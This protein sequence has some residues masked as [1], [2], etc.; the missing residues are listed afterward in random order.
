VTGVMALFFLAL[1]LLVEALQVP[2][3]TDPSRWMANGGM[4]AALV[5][6]G[7]LVADVLLPVPSSLIMIAHG[8]LF[9]VIA[10]SCLSLVGSTGAALAAFA[11]GR[12]GGPLLGRLVPR[13]ERERADRLLKKYGALAIVITRPVPILAE[14]VA[15]MA[16][17]ATL[18]WRRMLAASAAGSLPAAVLYALTGAVAASFQNGVLMF[19]LVLFIAGIFWVAGRY[20]GPVA[21]EDES[22]AP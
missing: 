18:G 13:D 5:G 21:L 20:L 16:G 17:A 3:L 4:A 2:L 14:T 6:V 11:L 8:A 10:G 7:L 1:F 12:R 15:I 9:G 19:A 22:R